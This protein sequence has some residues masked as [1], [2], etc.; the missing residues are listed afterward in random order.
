MIKKILKIHN[1]GRFDAYKPRGDVE[2]TPLCFVFADN[3]RGKTTLCDIFRSLQLG[4]G[5]HIL[6][7]RR[8]GATTETEVDIQLATGTAKF[9]SGKWDVAYPDIA[10]FDNTFVHQNVF[11][12]DYV[13]H[14]HKRNLYR[15]I[16][17]QDG[18]ALA[19]LVDDLDSRIKDATRDLGQKKQAI[20][21]LIPPGITIDTFLTVA[22]L[23][24]VEE[25]IRAKEKELAEATAS[26]NRAAEIKEK[27]LLK[28]ASLPTFPVGFKELL[29]Q[30]LE[31][32]SSEAEVKMKEHIARHTNLATEEWLSKGIS[33][34]KDDT[35]PLCGQ[36]MSGLEL[37]AAYRSIFDITYQEFK[38]KLT[39]A[40]VALHTEFSGSP[41]ELVRKIMSDNAVW[42]EFWKQFSSLPLEGNPPLESIVA[43][44]EEA[45]TIADGLLRLKLSAPLEVVRWSEELEIVLKKYEELSNVVAEYNHKIEDSNT[46]IINVKEW[47]Q[48]PDL[49]GIESQLKFLKSIRKRFEPATLKVVEDYTKANK[50][51][52]DLE[53][54][55]KTAKEKLDKYSDT[56]LRDCEKRVNELLEMF[57]AGFSI[58][59][60]KRSYIGARVE[61]FHSK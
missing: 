24:D 27:P 25:K 50:I 16:V 10:I 44:V 55:K 32:I 29:A 3:G 20:E 19:K 5:D 33:Y 35:C 37:I 48:N 56:V 52:Y 59:S 4:E 38:N 34:A 40:M 9:R 11:A 61:M 39:A 26:K 31:N 18:V 21:L 60:T 45:K 57:G 46:R 42:V 30:T 13:D 51:K 17:G 12:G 53:T 2:L 43:V 6:G 23:V 15:V 1:V 41:L 22:P 49:A 58:G 8:L 47:A 36:E 54:E 14:E 7:R 28:P